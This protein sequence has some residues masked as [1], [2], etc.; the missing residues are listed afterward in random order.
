MFLFKHVNDLR[1][2]LQSEREKGKTIGFAPTMGALHQGHISLIQ[3]SRQ[4]SDIT[5]CSIFVNPTQ[6]NEQNDL[7]KYPRTPEMDIELLAVAGTDVLFFPG[8]EDIYPANLETRLQ[9]DFGSLDK[10][11]E[12][13]F[14]PGHF[15]GMAQ[16]V[17][18][19]L[20]IVEPQ[21][22]Y[23][24]Q[25]DYQQLT[26]VRRMLELNHIPTELVMCPTVREEDGLAMSS[27]N[28]RLSPEERSQASLIY[29][30]LAEAR[31]LMGEKTPADI[32]ANALAQLKAQGFRPEYFE[33]VDGRTLLPV[34]LFD[35][36]DF[37]VACTAVWVGNVRLIDNMVLKQPEMQEEQTQ[38]WE[39]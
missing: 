18:R 1:R 4:E 35:E 7:D 11:M 28:I 13:G 17:N 21:K 20:G 3:L 33:I 39:A 6:F 36:S 30:L 12:G 38:E 8:V 19:L 25:K 27:R 14:R 2:Y 23:M 34:Q 24:G 5:V 16:V 15:A 22:L 31:D 9:L 29:R 10:V 26:I 32:Q 37:M